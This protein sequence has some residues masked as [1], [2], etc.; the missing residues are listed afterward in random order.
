ML[1]LIHRPNT[2]A[3]WLG[4]FLISPSELELLWNRHAAKLRLLA[5]V[6][7]GFADDGA[8]DC[9]QE[10]F[11]RLSQQ[12]AV[13]QDPV[14]W[15]AKVTRNLALTERR[16]GRRRRQRETE[17]AYQ[18]TPWLVRASDQQEGHD[19]RE[20]ASAM[21]HL[22]AELK[23]LVVAIIWNQMTFRQV[24][25]VFDMSAATAHRRYKEALEE[26]RQRLLNESL[27]LEKS[28]STNISPQEGATE[29]E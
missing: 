22:S 26:L 2:P 18:K 21:Q 25:E 5:G 8:D 28:E 15:L 11:I 6:R 16:S 9:V 17:T 23:E 24:A 4:A 14:A 7:C 10:A 20:V 27:A 3:S 13:P 1:T 29:D 12:E 19:P